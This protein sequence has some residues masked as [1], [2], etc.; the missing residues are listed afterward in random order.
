MLRGFYQ[1]LRLGIAGG[2]A[3]WL[4]GGCGAW[5]HPHKAKSYSYDR[6]IED[7]DRDPTFKADPERADEEVRDVQ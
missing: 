3:I 2:L 4:L 6:N 5:H 1:F 7:E